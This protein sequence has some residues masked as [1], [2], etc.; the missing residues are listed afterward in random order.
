MN[1][2]QPDR[3]QSLSEEVERVLLG[4]CLRF[5]ENVQV[6]LDR[7]DSEDFSS[8]RNREIFSAIKTLYQRNAPID[9]LSVP[10]ELKTQEK[11]ILP[12]EVVEIADGFINGLDLDYHIN[13]LKT[14]SKRRR[15]EAI[16]RNALFKIKDSSLEYPEVEGNLLR[17]IAAM[18]NDGSVFK[19]DQ[20][21]LPTF[22]EIYDLNIKV[23]WT[24][25]KLIPKNAVTVLHGKGG[26]RKTW[27]LMQLGSSVADGKP[28]CG[29]STIKENVYY[30]DF[31]N[32]MAVMC[33][34]VR[35]LG[36]SSV[37]LWHLSHNPPPPRLDNVPKWETYKCLTP[38]LII[39]D[40]L[41]AAHFLDENSSKDMTTIM[42]RLKELREV[43]H[44]VIA[45]LHA[46]K[47]DERT[48]K[49]STALIDQADHALGFERVRQVG[50]DTA[51]DAE[52]E[53]GLPF[54]LGH[55]QKTRF[56]P[57]K[58]YLKFYLEKGFSLAPDP[59]Q[60]ILEKMRQ[61]LLKHYRDFGSPT[62]T[63]FVDIVKPEVNVSREKI[64]D[65]IKKGDGAFWHPL[66]EKKFNRIIYTP[67][68][69]ED[70]GCR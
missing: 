22:S 7:L 30:I 6:I 21:H 3:F 9:L 49:G 19:A 4:A 15:L 43:G 1:R 2:I 60:K 29:L 28:F 56:T 48:Y 14:Y 51:V 64:I 18:V 57:F 25:D 24:V 17:E 11:E 8:P 70:D 61:V 53:D 27:L 10:N 54:R 35:A 37:T 32:P 67:V 44:T 39:F 23:E 20:L 58:M 59:E 42:S 47:A 52:D 26:I 5:P 55:I 50:A 41:R 46:P 16:L 12:S 33:D 45:L 69:Y 13:R 38:G 68:F 34:R 40:S 65:F 31:E 36:R 62:Q 63:K 66:N